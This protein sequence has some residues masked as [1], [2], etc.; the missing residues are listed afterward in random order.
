MNI[1]PSFNNLRKANICA[2]ISLEHS[3]NIFTEF[4]SLF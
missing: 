1:N 2:A 3:L 4:G